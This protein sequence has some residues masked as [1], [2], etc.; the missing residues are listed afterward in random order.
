[1]FTC[2]RSVVSRRIDRHC[3]DITLGSQMVL[4]HVA[5]EARSFYQ[6][7]KNVPRMSVMI[8]TYHKRRK[9]EQVY[10][11]SWTIRRV[12]LLV[13]TWWNIISM[14]IG[15]VDL[16]SCSDSR[17]FSDGRFRSAWPV[18]AVRLTRVGCLL[19]PFW[20]SVWPVLAVCLTRV[21]CPLDPCWLSAWPRVGCLLD[22]V[23]AVARLTSPILYIGYVS[24]IFCRRS[25]K[26][27]S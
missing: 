20:L 13:I 3:W 26:F 8:L 14:F 27:I 23:L 25:T 21:G 11:S 17:A 6:Q 2:M 18:L 4:I 10:L 1:M 19:D 24:D 5:E 12:L 15:S 22:P 9:T 16:V 7:I